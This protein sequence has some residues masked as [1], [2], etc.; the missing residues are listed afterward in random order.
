L[1][2]FM[3]PVEFDSGTVL[4]KQLTLSGML[5]GRYGENRRN[6]RI[7]LRMLAYKQLDPKPLLSGTMPFEDIQKAIDSTYSGENLAV[8]L[9]P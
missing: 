7:A 8:L 4:T 1:A 6:G 2:G 9:K 5:A 3:P